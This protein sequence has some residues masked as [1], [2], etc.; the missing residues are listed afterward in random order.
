MYN[1][2]QDKTN[3]FIKSKVSRKGGKVKG[4]IMAKKYTEENK[5][6]VNPR[7][8]TEAEA[9]E[10]VEELRQDGFT[11]SE[12]L[13]FLEDV[14]KAKADKKEYAEQETEESKNEF[15]FLD[16][17]KIDRTALDDGIYEVRKT[18]VQRVTERD[19]DGI[20]INSKLIMTVSLYDYETDRTV[21]T[22][23]TYTSDYFDNLFYYLEKFFRDKHPK[24]MLDIVKCCKENVWY[25]KKV[26]R[27]MYANYYPCSYSP[28]KDT[29]TY[30]RYEVEE[31]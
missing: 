9:R 12:I 5:W 2:K 7:T 26:T 27:G 14:K 8:C 30:S 11:E 23:V 31:L 6:A 21:E 13:D 10:Y 25:I 17:F 15:D 20:I 24:N 28:L 1:N 19:E 18:S 4:K 22:K 16:P 3:G 29:T